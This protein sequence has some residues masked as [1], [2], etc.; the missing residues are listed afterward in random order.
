MEFEH[1]GQLSSELKKIG[2]TILHFRKN[3]I[4]RN[5]TRG[6]ELEVP[7]E[8]FPK[9]ATTEQLKWLY[10]VAIKMNSEHKIVNYKPKF[11]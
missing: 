9:K 5:F 6:Y 7:R 4:L 1:Y 3:I 10:E 11:W 2:C 8:L